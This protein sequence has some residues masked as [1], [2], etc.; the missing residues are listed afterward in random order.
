MLVLRQRHGFTESIRVEIGRD[1][2]LPPGCRVAGLE[3]AG[4]PGDLLHRQQSLPHQLPCLDRAVQTRERPV[5]LLTG[6]WQ[7]RDLQSVSHAHRQRGVAVDA[8][9]ESVLSP[10]ANGISAHPSVQHVDHRPGP[11]RRGRTKE[12][13]GVLL[14]GRVDV[15]TTHES[16]Q[17]IPDTSLLVQTVAHGQAK[18]LDERLQ[19]RVVVV[20]GDLRVVLPRP[21][22][23]FD[24]FLVSLAQRRR[25]D[26]CIAEHVKA[27]L[28][29]YRL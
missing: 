25:L 12:A 20:N 16:D 6:R 28:V 15:A 17:A 10:V 4:N 8:V 27:A 5:K 9:G 29:D 3:Y 7:G 18:H 24:A 19:C 2:T 11:E 26:G 23:S 1:R 22:E 14:D 13:S 21:H